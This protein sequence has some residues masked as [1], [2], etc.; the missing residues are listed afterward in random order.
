MS[1]TPPSKVETADD[2]TA[3]GMPNAAGHSLVMTTPGGAVADVKFLEEKDGVDNQDAHYSFTFRT[4]NPIPTSG[5]MVFTVPSGIKIPLNDPSG[6][7]TLD[8]ISTC[9]DAGATMTYSDITRLLYIKNIF[10]SYVDADTTFE[11]SIKGWT[12]PSDTTEQIWTIATE[13]EEGADVY[14]IDSHTGAKL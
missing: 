1:V 7:L 9:T 13:W 14:K 2:G 6:Q 8:C 5:Y 4:D 12:N 11:F 3:D 10:N